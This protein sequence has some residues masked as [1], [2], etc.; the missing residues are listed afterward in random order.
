[1]CGTI[2]F[3][4]PSPIH[5]TTAEGKDRQFIYLGGA[6]E[7]L[8]AVWYG[9][10]VG[11]KRFF[12]DSKGLQICPCKGD[13]RGILSLVGSHQSIASITSKSKSKREFQLGQLSDLGPQGVLLRMRCPPLPAWWSRTASS[14]SSSTCWARHCLCQCISR[15]TWVASSPPPLQLL[16]LF[17]LHLHW[18]V[19]SLGGGGMGDKFFL[20]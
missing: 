13:S 18:P 10:V 20:D 9:L 4:S 2:F 15:P 6:S 5:S 19:L 14:T 17:R 8:R 12:G 16:Q 1:M 11:P 7:L 3:G